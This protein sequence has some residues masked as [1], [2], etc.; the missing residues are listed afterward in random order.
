VNYKYDDA[1]SRAAIHY[2]ASTFS[3]SI[4]T[5][6]GEKTAYIMCKPNNQ[7]MINYQLLY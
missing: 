7:Q 1:Q 2:V 4:H 6:S 3:S 5:G